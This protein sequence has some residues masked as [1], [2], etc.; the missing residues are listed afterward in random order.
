MKTVNQIGETIHNWVFFSKKK[1]SF[2]LRGQL[3]CVIRLHFPRA[4]S[5]LYIWLV[6]SIFWSGSWPLM[7]AKQRRRRR[8][9]RENK[10][11]RKR[12][13][14]WMTRKRTTMPQEMK[15]S[16]RKW[17]GRILPME[18]N[19]IRG[20]NHSLL[21]CNMECCYCCL[22]KMQICPFLWCVS[23]CHWMWKCAWTQS[24]LISMWTLCF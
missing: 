4:G 14:K 7:A 16:L 9:S 18:T 21:F 1:Y 20:E 11:Q 22:S 19:A 5:L 2:F 17:K 6:N 3:G 8:R 10:V 15:S 24:N 23:M 13:M 12:L